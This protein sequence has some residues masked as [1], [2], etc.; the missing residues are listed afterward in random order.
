MDSLLIIAEAGINHNGSLEL[1]KKLADEAKLAGADAVKFQ[2]F[3]NMGRLEEYEFTIT[4][5]FKL[6]KYCDK[7]G[8]T[9]LTTPHTIDSISFVDSLV[10]IHKIASPH[11][12]EPVFLYK[13][14]SMKKP[15]LLATGNSRNKTG[16]ATLRQIEG[17]LRYLKNANITLL[18][19]VSKYPCK[20]GQYDEIDR[21][22]KFGYPVG[23]SD[24][25]KNVELPRGLSV[26]EKHLMLEDM[27]CIDKSVSLTPHQFK[28]MTD[29]IRG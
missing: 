16:M 13:I 4:Q 2:T 28:E 29:Y 6:K 14:A 11:L 18:H 7:I 1:A 17:A 24:H 21:L 5:W 23:L 19:C 15:I 9:F 20:N 22:N 25:T 3:W 12:T 10:P 8:I 27:D 26:Y